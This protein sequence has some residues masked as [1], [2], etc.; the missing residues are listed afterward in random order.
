MCN[1]LRA[2][3]VVCVLNIEYSSLISTRNRRNIET[4]LFDL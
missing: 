1:I 4:L 3:C 2:I